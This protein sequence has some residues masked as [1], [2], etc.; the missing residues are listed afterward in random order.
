MGTFLCCA[1]HPILIVD[2]NEDIRELYGTCLRGEGYTVLEAEDG[3]AALDTLHQTPQVPCLVLLDLMMPIMSGPEFLK[4][5]RATHRL[6][7]LPIIVISAGGQPSDAPGA[8][9][10]VR[11]PLDPRALVAL[12]REYCRPT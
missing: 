10:F 12:V 3:Q 5:V 4:A 9:R 8:N 7:S 11:K 2:D 1:M 6:A